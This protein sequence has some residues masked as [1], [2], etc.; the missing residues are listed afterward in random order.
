MT[1]KPPSTK[2]KILGKSL[3]LFNEQGERKVTTNHIAAELGISPG[4]LYY[5]F[6]NKAEIIYELFLQFEEQVVAYMS[7][8]QGRDLNF[9]DKISYFEAIFRIM[10][11]YRFFHRDLAHLMGENQALR[12]RYS[13]YTKK[14][15]GQARI[16][17]YKLVESDILAAT[18]EEIE[19]L[20][21]NTWVISSSWASFLYTTLPTLD[22]ETISQDLIKRG[23]Y[24]I[25][26]LEAP[27][28]TEK[29]RK[30]LPRLME[31]YRPWADYQPSVEFTKVAE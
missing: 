27:Y 6:S 1:N 10:W 17:Y 21:I 9:D 23:I 26:C 19:A 25:V 2:D 28:L 13:E 31:I 15:L 20:I 5:H 4:N 3:E 11:D 14:A 30:E 16:V 29:A 18:E 24:Q 8:P 22:E 12:L 7:V